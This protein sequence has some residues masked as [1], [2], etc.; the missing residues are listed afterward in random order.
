MSHPSSSLPFPPT[1][2]LTTGRCFWATCTC[3][4]G[5]FDAPS[6]DPASL[7]CNTCG[8]YFKR[9]T[10][11]TQRTPSV[12]ERKKLPERSFIPPLHCLFC[13]V[14]FCS[15]HFPDLPGVP[16][17]W[18]RRDQLV[19]SIFDRMMHYRILHIRGTPAS[20]KTVLL[21][22]LR[23]HIK[24]I[25]PDWNVSVVVDW[26]STLDNDDSGTITHLERVL[27][28]RRD[29][30]LAA[31]DTVLLLDEAQTTY[32]NRYFWNM[33]LKSIERISGVYVVLFSSY[34]SPKRQPVDL[35]GLTP[36]VLTAD[37]RIGLQIDENQG[38]PPAGLLLTITEAES[39]MSLAS[40]AHQDHPQFS[41]G[42]LHW[43]YALTAGHVGAFVG[44]L[45][46]IIRSPVSFRSLVTSFPVQVAADRCVCNLIDTC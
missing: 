43:V 25:K 22:L 2:R 36:P 24:S 13:S 10:L 11:E 29:D 19:E 9:H 3:T 45:D 15:V 41:H 6:G 46:M 32:K 7:E 42:L 16:L 30:F 44:I 1:V 38:F 35:I 14:L 37:Q 23:Y 27:N 34:G 40:S 28:L 5:S 31:Q 12:P 8:H 17:D 39:I 18:C 21:Q 20:G 26:P 4:A 33:F